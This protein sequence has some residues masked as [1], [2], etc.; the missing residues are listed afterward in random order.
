[1]HQIVLLMQVRFKNEGA[2]TFFHSAASG[3]PAEVL[4]P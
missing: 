1:M 2:Q 4:M 3:L